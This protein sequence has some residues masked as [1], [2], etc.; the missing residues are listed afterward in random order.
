MTWYIDKGPD[1]DVVLSSRIRLA[2]NLESYPF[3]SKLDNASSEKISQE[4]K[5]S[6]HEYFKRHK[7]KFVDVA[8]NDLNDEEKLALVEKHIIS[9]DLTKGRIHRYAVI[10]N[11]ESVS[12]MINEED[13]VRIQA[14]EAGLNLEAAQKNAQDVAFFLEKNL[15][16]AYHEK[17]GF[18][19]SCP[20]NTGTG[21]RASVIMHLPGLVLTQK[22]SSVVEKVQ[23]MAYSVRGY[24]GENSSS[25]GNM[26][27]I[28]NQITLGLA[29]D[30][31][32]SDLKKLIYQIMEQERAIRKDIYTKN[33]LYIEDM[34]FRSLGLLKYARVL[35]SD[36]SLRMISDVRLG[37][38]LGIIKDVEDT[39]IN[40]LMTLVGPASVQ[41][42]AGR[43]MEPKERDKT[44]AFVIRK[45]LKDGDS[46]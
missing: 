2:R 21:L 40:R 35:T 9:E 32:I 16:V 11:D 1:S 3:P 27:Q 24:Y 14:M 36:E 15:P 38:A 33:P 5:N 25:I 10:R 34:V 31:L 39:S 6:L 28:S 22:I 30:E 37:A 26:F 44:R 41:K 45:E 43:V 23:K 17:F 42:E 8:M 20:T 19:T 13:H 18:L 4:I 12:V 7:Q 46:K 29:E